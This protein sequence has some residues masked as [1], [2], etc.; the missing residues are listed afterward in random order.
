MDDREKPL[1]GK[2]SDECSCFS[3][4]ISFVDSGTV[5]IEGS[6]HYEKITTDYHRERQIFPDRPDQG[7]G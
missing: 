5:S 2:Y 4:C 1:I 3:R 6:A 7:S